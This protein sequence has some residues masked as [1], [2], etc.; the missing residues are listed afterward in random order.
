MSSLKIPSTNTTHHH[1]FFNDSF[2]KYLSTMCWETDDYFLILKKLMVFCI[3]KYACKYVEQSQGH[4]KLRESFCLDVRNDLTLDKALELSLENL[5][6]NS[7][8]VVFQTLQS[9]MEK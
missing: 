4:K 6:Q 5:S 7:K 9:G 8:V 1:S 2:T 3:S